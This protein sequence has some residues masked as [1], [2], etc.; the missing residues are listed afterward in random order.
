M[1]QLVTYIFF[2]T[3]LFSQV[4]QLKNSYNIKS[5]DVYAKHLYKEVQSNFFIFSIP[6]YSE[7]YKISSRKI[8][9]EFA[10]RGITAQDNKTGIVTFIRSE[11]FN[12]S[13]LKEQLE[14]LFIQNL[15][16]LQIESIQLI[17]R[18][19]LK[20][21]PRDYKVVLKKTSLKRN[22]GSFY[23]QTKDDRF[24]FSFK[25]KATLGVIKAK[26][27]IRSKEIINIY[28]TYDDEIEFT[29]FNSTPLQNSSLEHSIVTRSIKKDS[30]ITQRDIKKIPLV[31]KNERV[32]V[33]FEN[34]AVSIELDVKAL[35]DGSL[36]D[37]I[38]VRKSDGTRLNVTVTAKGKAKL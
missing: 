17:S 32:R 23:I 19:N 30:I 9:E 25:I 18:S 16:T 33:S 31:R 3:L 36:G 2:T 14:K 22:E 5:N 12:S 26:N 35:K 34:G 24:F 21:L 4:F 7:Q 15:P 27:S 6:E 29:N 10:K 1:K 38:P 13:K 28:N 11:N 37:I 20:Q 8:I